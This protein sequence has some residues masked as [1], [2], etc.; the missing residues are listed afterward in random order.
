[1]STDPQEWNKSMTERINDVQAEVRNL[2]EGDAQVPSGG[3]IATPDDLAK[4]ME[5]MMDEQLRNPPDIRNPKIDDIALRSED[6]VI[7]REPTAYDDLIKHGPQRYPHLYTRL[8][9]RAPDLNYRPNSGPS[10]TE[11]LL[12]KENEQLRAENEALHLSLSQWSSPVMALAMFEGEKVAVLIGRPISTDPLIYPA[13][14]TEGP[15]NGENFHAPHERL[16][17]IDP[18]TVTTEGFINGLKDE[19]TELR[20]RLAKIQAWS[21]SQF[22]LYHNVIDDSLAIA[23][24]WWNDGMDLINPNVDDD[25]PTGD[26][27]RPNRE[28]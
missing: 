10:I 20:D 2:I 24:R 17:F 27:P 15:K 21:Q 8:P 13:Q 9:W 12:S 5:S 26:V 14:Y 11:E 25:P 22:P 3:R 6:T 23:R 28:A 1:M 18:V 19:I 7:H 4:A 16:Q